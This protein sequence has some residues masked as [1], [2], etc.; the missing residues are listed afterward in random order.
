MNTT[1]KAWQLSQK[2][3]SKLELVDR[4]IPHAGVDEVVIRLSA[5][6]LNY[7][8]LLVR[9]QTYRVDS[10]TYPLIPVS[11]G[12]GEIV[13]V[14]KNVTEWKLGDRV[15][16]AFRPRWIDGALNQEASGSALGA[17]TVDGVL[18]DY[19]ALPASGVLAPPAHLTDAEAATLPCA[20]VT[21]WNALFVS[22]SLKPGDTVLVLGTGGVSLFALQFAKLG[23]AR[24]ILTSSEDTKLERGRSLG[25]DETINYRKNPDWSKEVVERTAGRGVDI[26]IDVVGGKGMNSVLNCVSFGGTVALVGVIEGFEGPLS[27]LGFLQRAI[28]L[29]GISVGSVAMFR[30]MNHAIAF[31]R[32]RPVIDRVFPFAEAPE[33]YAHLA[34][35]RHFGKVLIER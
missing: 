26:A 14:G 8:D 32:L 15:A 9:D 31:G 35:G 24:V 17:G 34:S 22:Y 11:D 13:Q 23:G 5:A 28:R 33:A 20:A 25:A 29:Q 7:R 21:A 16:G 19:I 4:T 10:G 27:A 1:M 2:T 18:A 6:S 12:V 3:A 30:A